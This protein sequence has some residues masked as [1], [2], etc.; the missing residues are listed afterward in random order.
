[1]L[2]ST[3]RAVPVRALV[4]VLSLAG[5]GCANHHP[6]VWVDKLAPQGPQLYRI[7]VGDR[8][9][10]LVK[11]QQ[12]L[13]GDFE[14]LPTGGYMQPLVGE[15]SV[16]GMTL[17][18]AGDL[19]K[20]RLQGIVNSPEVTISVR[21]LRTLQ[22]NV[23]GEVRQPGTFPIPFGEGVL[24]VLARAGG[25]TE[26]ADSSAIYVIRQTPELLRVRFRYNDLIGGDPVALSFKLKDGDVVVVED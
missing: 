22:I 16:T 15:L 23:L 25:L 11:N 4:F 9:S 6:F 1:M 3:D 2:L 19:L 26:F 8:L 17:N 7:A 18:E 21:T 10:V 20:Q 12:Q 13:S 5:A 24:T 14:V